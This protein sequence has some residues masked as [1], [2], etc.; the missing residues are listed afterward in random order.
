MTAVFLDGFD[1]YG[2]GTAGGKAMLNG[3][4][5]QIEGGGSTGV[6]SFGTRTGEFSLFSSADSSGAY[7]LILP[8]PLDNMFL[9]FGYAVEGLPTGNL[10]QHLCDFRDS[11]NIAIASVQVQ[12]TGDVVL[13]AANGT[14]ILASTQ[15]PV[16]VSDNWHFIEMNFNQSGGDF[17]LRV[18]DADASG[19]PAITYTGGS[20]TNAVAQISV[21]GSAEFG[22]VNSWLDDLFV[23]DTSG[24]VNN[25]W[26]GDRR[27]GTLF[28]DADTNVKGWTP[29]YYKEFGAGILTLGFVVPNNTTPQNNTA[30]LYCAPASSL[31]IGNSDFTLETMV[32]FDQLPAASHYHSIFSRWNVTVPQLSYRLIL[33][34]SSFN[35]GCL[36]FDTSTDGTGST[37]DTP[38]LFPW[39][40]DLNRWYHLALC[41]SA[42]ELLLFIDGQQL[43]LPISDT[44]TYFTGGSEP[45]GVGAEISTSGSFN[46]VVANTT[47]I[48]RLDE[49][50]FTNGVGRYTGPFTPP[51]AAFPR[52][53][54][55]DPDWSSVALLMGYDSGITD[56]SGFARTVVV[57]NGAVAFFPADG[58]SLGLY[59]TVDKSN[60]DDN[61]FISAGLTN[62]TNVL[63]MTTKPSNG[64][65]VTV[66]TTDGTTAA[67]YTFKT[68]ISTAFDVLIDTT[69]QTTLIN[70][71]NAINAGTGSG[72]KYG[73]GTTSNF[74]VNAV[75]LPAGQIEVV[76]NLAGTAGNSIASTHTGTT[77]SW[78]SSTLTG[79]ADIP[80]PTEFLMQ[81]PPNN[82]TIISALQMTVR[83]LKTDA[84][85]SD[86]Q[87]TFIAPL[88]GTAAGATHALS[89]SPS[90][91]SDIIELDPD[92]SGPLTPTTIV[93]GKF[94]INRT[95]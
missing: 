49:T 69:A 24:S 87:S 13:V 48:G 85:L 22:S 40:P 83:A 12:S 35:N 54:G 84:G 56:E 45:L 76:A 64:D 21:L 55:S 94:K 31:D 23:R 46:T 95:S 2:S 89:T 39:V 53:S 19:T 37:L 25:S 67:V 78:A 81:R 11:S 6:P 52:G 86:I 77:A 74:D 15:G 62:A 43:G 9:S 57:A 80:G 88:G 44:N 29:S 7:R 34:G 63:T 47:F 65:T 75:Q 70:L 42:S 14:T 26:L 18:D 16:I 91:Y 30:G 90:Y 58:P 51:A 92:T 41:R 79:G 32:R 20:F 28:A 3:T 8:A 73:T 82:T 10:A 1:H 27:I 50:R 59:S 36:Q 5:A 60:P 61:T 71:L 33:G 38:I 17:T 66:G 72:T 4:W 68:S 93:N